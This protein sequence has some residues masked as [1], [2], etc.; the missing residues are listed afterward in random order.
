[1]TPF[2]VVYGREPPPLLRF[3]KGVAPAT[4]VEQQ[5]LERDLVLDE[6]KA[7]LLRAQEL[8]K[9]RADSKRR[10]VAFEEGQLVFLKIRP[11]R[12]R[13]LA[14]RANKK[15]VARYYGPYT[16]EKRIGQVAYRLKLPAGCLLH[17]VVHV[18]QLRDAKGATRATLEL[19]QQV[20]KELE[21]V[22]EPEAVLG[23]CPGTGKH[24]R[25][26][27]MLI[28]WK[29]LPPLEATWEVFSLIQQ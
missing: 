1:L 22:V 23:I 16:V 6:L 24:H 12:Q 11:Y 27:E 28:Q 13:S 4:L 10:D 5:L 8:M 2:Q 25:D 15:L 29:G 7:Q 17:P 9:K 26:L 19:P 14:T 3:E 18:S 21:M 20:T